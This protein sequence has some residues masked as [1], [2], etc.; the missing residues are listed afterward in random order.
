MVSQIK[1][2]YSV[3]VIGECIRTYYGRLVAI[4]SQM[5]LAARSTIWRGD[6]M[7]VETKEERK[8]MATIGETRLIRVGGSV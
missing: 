6:W 7:T 3:E 5:S 8:G 2:G 1:D 4:G